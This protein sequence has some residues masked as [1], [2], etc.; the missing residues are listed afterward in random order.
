MLIKQIEKIIQRLF[1]HIKKIE[2][3]N[4]RL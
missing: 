4:Q 3:I 1:M 2:K